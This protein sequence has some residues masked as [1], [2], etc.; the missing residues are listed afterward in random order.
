MTKILLDSELGVR[1]RNILDNMGIK[2]FDDLAKKRSSEILGQRNLGRTTLREIQMALAARGL[3]LAD[4]KQRP[5]IQNDRWW[6][7]FCAVPR[8]YGEGIGSDVLA[9]ACADF[10]DAAI[11]EAKK[12]GLI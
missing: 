4:E 6:Q 12:R 11:A 8:D 1:A 9:M 5:L 10:A 7:A 2:T 3:A